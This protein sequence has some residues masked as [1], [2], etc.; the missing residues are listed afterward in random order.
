MLK[1]R[2]RDLAALVLAGAAVAVHAAGPSP[3][4]E[5]AE[6]YFIAPNNGAHVKSPVRVQFG[7]RG[8]GVAPAGVEVP[9]TGHHHLL[10]NADPMPDM[11]QP[12]P[13]SDAVRHFGKG[14]TETE[15]ALEPGTYTL[16]LVLGNA[17]HVP[18]DPPITSGTITITVEP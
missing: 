8:M 7:L 2:L 11:T 10:I 4:P 5:G 13:S 17:R 14:Q 16:Q 6:L 1:S 9:N 15:V 18:F 3:A 12:L